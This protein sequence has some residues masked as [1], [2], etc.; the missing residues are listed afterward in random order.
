MAGGLVFIHAKVKDKDAESV[1]AFDAK[2]GDIKWEKTYNRAVIK[3]FFGNG[4]RATPCAADGT[5]FTFG[6]TGVLTAWE[7]ES[8][9]Q[10]W[11]VD[12]LKDYK[13]KNLMFGVSASPIIVSDN[14]VVM[15]GK[16]AAL[17]A[18]ARKGGKEAW[19][20]GSDL[21]SYSSPVVL[22]KQLCVLTGENVLG[23]SLDGKELWKYPF[24]D[25]LFESSSTLVKAEGVILASAIKAGSVGIKATEKDGKFAAEPAW[26]NPKLTCYFSTPVP[27][28]EGHVYLVTGIPVPTGGSITLHCVEM[29]TGDVKWSK[30]KVG[31]YHAAFLK[32]ADGKLLMHDDEGNLILLEPDLKEY[33]ELARSKV[34]GPTWAH[35]AVA[36]GKL[37]LRDGKDLLC[38][39]LPTK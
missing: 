10:L 13:A 26:K 39:E 5:L 12:T 31:K 21:A 6:L 20:A 15:V 28:G 37:F 24:K 1:T 22:D 11:Q 25:A 34:G 27:V 30:P 2:T 38:V 4:P 3:T 16:P 35:P 29:K 8:G 36:G 32:M 7:A 14:V 17:V 33:K 23:V 19:Q 9:K 18:F